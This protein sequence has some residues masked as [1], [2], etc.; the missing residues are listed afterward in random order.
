MYSIEVLPTNLC[1][2][3]WRLISILRAFGLNVTFQKRDP[4]WITRYPKKQNVSFLGHTTTKLFLTWF[5]IL[6]CTPCSQQVVFVAPCKGGKKETELYWRW[7]EEVKPPLPRDFPHKFHMAAILLE[8]RRTLPNA[9]LAR[10]QKQSAI[11]SHTLPAATS[12]EDALWLQ[13]TV[14][15]AETEFPR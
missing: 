11:H 2:R 3:P 1:C 5:I 8:V 4:S 14:R 13:V 9:I 7:V 15:H 12:P 6:P 10:D